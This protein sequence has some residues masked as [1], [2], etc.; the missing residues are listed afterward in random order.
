MTFYHIGWLVKTFGDFYRHWV[1]FTYGNHMTFYRHWVTFT[2]R[3]CWVT[4][5]ALGN[6]YRHWATFIDIGRYFT[7]NCL[8]PCS[9]A[10]ANIA[11]PKWHICNCETSRVGR[12][13]TQ[14]NRSYLENSLSYCVLCGPSEWALNG[15]SAIVKAIDRMFWW[16]AFQIFSW[17][18]AQG[19]II[20]VFAQGRIIEV[21]QSWAIQFHVYCP[22]EKAHTA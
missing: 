14:L 17:T 22:C 15:I 6:F 21:A 18:I 20:E 4:F 9:K 11:V 16:N 2:N 19:R 8:S 10:T 12:N 13:F 7:Q 5:I 3:Q 1:T